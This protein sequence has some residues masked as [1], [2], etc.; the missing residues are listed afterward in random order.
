[1]AN[2]LKMVHGFAWHFVQHASYVRE[3]LL[4]LVLLIVLG[5]VTI[6]Y[7]EGLTLGESMYFSFVTGLTI[8]YGDIAPKTSEGRI[9]SV[10]IALVGLVFTGMFIAISNRTLKEIA[11]E[12]RQ[13]GQQ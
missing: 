4:A 1:M 10:C 13:K 8:G 11:D 3:I 9:V 2:R 6:S 7:C 5:G 12:H